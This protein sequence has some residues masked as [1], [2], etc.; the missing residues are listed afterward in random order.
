ML[1]FLPRK[2]STRI[3]VLAWTAVGLIAAGVVGYHYVL[4][5]GYREWREKRANSIA[6]EHLEKG[7]YASAITAARKA[8]QYNPANANA[9]KLA[10]EIA[11]KQESPHV[12]VYQ[13][14]LANASP[15]LENRLE[16][17]RVAI[18]HRAFTQAQDTINKI[19]SEAANSPEFYQL[20]AE[21][22]QLMRNPT[23]AKYYLMSLVKLQP[24]NHKARLD[25]AQHRLI[26][27]FEDNRESIR[28]E[29]RDL[30]TNAEHRIRALSLL[31]ADSLKNKQTNEAV[32]VAEQ[33]SKSEGLTPET[34][35]MIAEAYRQ[36]SPRHFQPYLAEL[37]TRF[38]ESPERVRTL[39]TYLNGYEQSADARAWIESLS[40]ELRADEG[41]QL[42]YARVLFGLKD[43][44]A[45]E[46]YLRPLKWTENEYARQALLA[47]AARQRGDERGFAELW[48]LSV[49]EVGNNPRRL[50]ALL[51]TVNGWAW[52][53]QRFELLW[54]KFTLDPSDKDVRR[55]LAQWERYRQNTPALN[56]LFARINE[57]EPGNREERNNY[58]YTS[59]LLRTALERAHRD[60]RSSYEFDPKNP[61]YIT[62]Y[63]FSLYRQ[64][65]P[66]EA[67]RIFETLN[68]G[69]ISTPERTLLHG[70]LLV[71]NGR[72][73]EGI[74][75]MSR[76]KLEDLL[77]EER[78]L[79]TEAVLLAERSRVGKARIASLTDNI[80]SRPEGEE[81]KSWLQ[82]LPA[83]YRS[84]NVQFELAD[85]LYAAD[86]YAQLETTLKNE[87]WP[88]HDF[89]RLALIAY[90]QRNLDR[91]SDF[92]TTWRMI[93]A[94]I[95][96]RVPDL[97]VLEEL[98]ERWGWA[99]QR[100]DVLN[101]IIQREPA[102]ASLY[103][104]AS[105]YRQQGQ[106]AELARIYALRVDA[107][108]PSADDRS[109]FAYYNLLANANLSRAH[110]LSKQAYDAAPENLLQVKA[111]AFSLFKQSRFTD[112]ARTVEK[113]LT[114][115]NA[116][117]FALLRAAI[118]AE[119]GNTDEAR[120]LLGTFSAE[121]ALPEESALAD[122]LAKSLAAKST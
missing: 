111:Y 76:L 84:D 83:A 63:A 3:I 59:L 31:L 53:E 85:A 19:G 29:I 15:T 42:A 91:G 112:A 20:A 41:V 119:Q 57:N 68:F 16:F 13:Q 115:A 38:A 102:G 27:G 14:G 114:D 66:Q 116:T 70:V 88:E 58:T 33:L 67:L 110:V 98:C 48:R 21:V 47:F 104:L 95:G 51:T 25:L 23:R 79:H 50:Q 107:E 10:V 113:A 99:S 35:L 118:A 9:W 6:R 106:T 7:D 96:H 54:K 44:S 100:I 101:R 90:A 37:K 77:P 26:D 46:S 73:D 120:K 86:A 89:L 28:A 8:I 43:Y 5:P 55:Q 22:S 32:E 109:Y 1:K 75:L 62:S 45:L 97:R 103:E 60:A 117:D 87:R 122:S 52:H 94:S 34:E 65:K 39:A 78:Q 72:A 92:I 12:F 93:E 61:F 82:T 24:D 18:K 71:A 105:Y 81:R 49:L 2:R 80:G 30:A 40:A 11:E 64:D 36:A 74:E 121:T 17:I 56:R 69:A 108:N 4:K